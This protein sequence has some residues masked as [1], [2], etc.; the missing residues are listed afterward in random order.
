MVERS[1]PYVSDSDEPEAEK[2]CKIPLVSNLLA[3]VSTAI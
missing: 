3:P 2:G 1:D